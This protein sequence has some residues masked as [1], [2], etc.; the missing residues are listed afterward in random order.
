MTKASDNLFPKVLIVEGS[1]PSSPSAGDQALFIDSADHKLK[2]KN[3]SGSVT[4]VEGSPADILDL[5]TA[6]TDASLVLA[7]DGAGGVEFRAET[8]SGG[9]TQEINEDGSSTANWTSVSG[10]WASSGGIISQTNNAASRFGL[11]YTNP[12]RMAR[13]SVKADIRLPSSGQPSADH[14]AGLCVG[15]P[16]G[17]PSGGEILVRIDRTNAG[18]GSA[19]IIRNTQAEILSVSTTIAF[20]TWYTIEAVVTDRSVELYLDGTFLVSG[21]TQRTLTDIR[22]F[23]L[24]SENAKADFRNIATYYIAPA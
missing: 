3:S 18:V 14:N 24:Q 13:C 9:W 19:K 5:P 21:D 20:D 6:E 8:G 16:S 7:P 17:G 1:A 2:R 12:V 15:V 11:R 10:T 22:Y 4:T 23:G